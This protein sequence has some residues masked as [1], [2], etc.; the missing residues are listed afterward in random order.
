MKEQI[1]VIMSALL[2]AA[3]LASC[4]AEKTE[5]SSTSSGYADSSWLEERIGT[6]PD[7]LTVGLS[8]S[9][10][11]D[12]TD[13]EEDGYIIR[14]EENE[15][16]LCGKTETGLDIAVRKYRRAV[17]YGYDVA[18]TVYH[19]GERIEKLTI[20][21]R[22]ISEYT[23]VYTHT[24]EPVVPYTGRTLGNG[25]FAATEFVRLIEEATGVTLSMSESVPETPYIL[26]EATEDTEEFGYTG[27][28]YE[29]KDGN[30]FFRGS[31]VSGGCSNGVYHFLEKNCGWEELTYG[32]ANLLEADEI[33]IPEGLSYVGKTMFGGFYTWGLS[34]AQFEQNHTIQGS[35]SP[36]A[37]HGIQNNKFIDDVDLTWYNPC[38]TDEATQENC[39][40]N[41]KIY[42]DNKI[43]SGQILGIT[44]TYVD[45]AQPDSEQWCSCKNCRKML[46]EEESQSGAVVNFCNIVSEAVNEE[47]PG[48]QYLFFAYLQTKQPPNTVRPNDLLS[49]T[50]CLDGNC[51]NHS[52]T[53]DECQTNTWK[54]TNG[55]TNTVICNWIRTWSTMCKD[56]RIWYYTM[57]GANTQY[58]TLDVLY[59]DFQFFKSIGISVIFMESEDYGH[60]VGRMNHYMGNA[61]FWN[62]DLT[63]DEYYAVLRNK[64]ENYYGE[65]SYDEYMKE[66]DL[67]RLATVRMGDACC[68]YGS[69]LFTGD[70][71]YKYFGE[72]ADEVLGYI[73][74]MI[75][76]AESYEQE[77]NG[78]RY[79]MML[80]YESLPGRYY[81]ALDNNDTVMYEHLSDLYQLFRE[82]AMECGYDLGLI[83]EGIGF[84]HT[85]MPTIEEEAEANWNGFINELK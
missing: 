63:K 74:E 34:Y 38:Y 16:I 27:F 2:L 59:E 62:P 28:S 72:K 26:F 81:A 71:D 46:K 17:K 10:G 18:E 64:V 68:W 24:V 5:I 70:T 40:D 76:D 60:G 51:Y 48:L 69:G 79:S 14:T 3:S 57:D 20:A 33:N 53:S 67:F 75:D 52:L 85:Y 47:Y 31:G 22:D 82:R 19:E 44:L 65:G 77:L 6:L 1:S 50:F 7:N 15:T 13:F 21:G 11:I 73:N 42:L 32:D 36:V 78:K 4:A 43:A 49:L 8:D 56:V 23:V 66:A 29:V 80:I 54:V 45:I 83:Y 58:N 61:M 84:G 39:I 35:Y 37:C 25:E 9:L 30:M 41:I 55:I 12:M